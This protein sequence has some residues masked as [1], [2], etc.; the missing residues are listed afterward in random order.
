LRPAPG[1]RRYWRPSVRVTTGTNG[2]TLAQN[3]SETVHDFTQTSYHLFTDKFLAFA[4]ACFC[5]NAPTN[6]AHAGGASFS[7]PAFFSQPPPTRRPRLH[8]KPH[9]VDYTVL[10]RN[11]RFSMAQKVVAIVGSYRKG[12][13]IDSAVQAIL[14]GAREH[15]AHTHAIYLTDQHLLFCTNCRRCTQAPGLQRGCCVQQDDLESIL[16]EIDA[17]DALV[18]GSPVNYWNATAI[19]R[20]FTER[21]LGAT[22]WPW[23]RARPACA[24]NTSPA[25][26]CWSP[27]LPCRLLHSHP[28]RGRARPAHH[29]QVPRHQA[30][31]NPLDWPRLQTARSALSRAPSPAP[32]ASA[33]PSPESLAVVIL[34]QVTAP[35]FAAAPS[36]VILA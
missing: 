30:R 11:G 3:T 34:A 12:G 15:G 4:F 7:P 9:I 28:H 36:V 23:D 8:P 25:R 24:R 6:L 5:T 10:A 20:Q 19:F 26:P 21:L 16:A 1:C 18:L 33:S 22:Y 31:R 29:R 27:R 32:A 13:A 35:S 14:A 2:S 17:A